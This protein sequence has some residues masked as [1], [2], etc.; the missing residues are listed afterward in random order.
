MRYLALDRAVY[1]FRPRP[2]QRHML[3]RLLQ[4]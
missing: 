3:V 2:Q 1:W 4:G